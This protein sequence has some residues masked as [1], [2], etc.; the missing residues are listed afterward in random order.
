MEVLVVN[1]KKSHAFV[2]LALK[3]SIKYIV[4]IV[5]SS[6]LAFLAVDSYRVTVF[7]NKNAIKNK[8]LR[9]L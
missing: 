8:S 1:Q 4:N 7:W 3:S 9:E 6:I 2:Y 5:R